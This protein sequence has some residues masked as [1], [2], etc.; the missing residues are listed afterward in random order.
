MRWRLRS[1]VRRAAKNAAVA[2]CPVLLVL[3]GALAAQREPA[4]D[5]S[6]DIAI[7]SSKDAS[8]QRAIFWAPPGTEK[9]P[10]VV[11]LHSWSTDYKTVG[12]ALEETR[13]RGW[14]FVGP[15][16]R[17]ANETPDACAS[18][19]AVQD[20]LDSVAYARK[21]AR[22]DEKR[23]YLVGSSGGGQMALLMA[24]RAPSRQST[25]TRRRRSPRSLPLTGGW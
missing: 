9:A 13:K 6:L 10:L 2:A 7:V 17:G 23:I 8:A 11:F 21:Q 1:R 16:F 20:I 22:V 12:P 14:I 3:A 19:L 5:P 18:D 4:I 15:N 24:T 25:T